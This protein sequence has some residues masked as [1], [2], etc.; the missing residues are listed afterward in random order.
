MKL[1]LS[2]HKLS[3]HYYQIASSIHPLTLIQ[4]QG[5]MHIGGTGDTQP[6]WP[7]LHYKR[8]NKVRF[9]HLACLLSPLNRV[10]ESR[11]SP[12]CC[13]IALPSAWLLSKV[14]PSHT[15]SSDLA[16]ASFVNGNFR[17]LES[18]RHICTSASLHVLTLTVSFPSLS[19]LWVKL[20][21]F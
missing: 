13:T 9:W 10:G 14:S 7:T 15:N 3:I 2:I 12:L 20:F 19:N 8:S 11:I 6:H 4:N 1:T 18:C 5:R 16:T 17:T 21:F